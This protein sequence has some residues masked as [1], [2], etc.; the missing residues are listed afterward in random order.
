M[1]ADKT[2]EEEASP[3]DA[4]SK[5]YVYLLDLLDYL[6]QNERDENCVNY[7]SKVLNTVIRTKPQE[8][9]EFFREKQEILDKIIRHTSEHPCLALTLVKLVHELEEKQY[10]EEKTV[11][12]RKIIGQMQANVNSCLAFSNYL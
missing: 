10:R 9:F 4:F 6:N 3:R 12:V 2:N 5:K 1:V 11:I 7:L 8:T